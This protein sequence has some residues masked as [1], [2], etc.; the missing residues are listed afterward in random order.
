MELSTYY[1]IFIFTF[2][3]SLFTWELWV[4]YGVVKGDSVKIRYD[5]NSLKNAIIMSFGDALVIVLI[6]YICVLVFK[7]N[8]FKD[9]K[10]FVLFYILCNFQ[11]IIVSILLKKRIIN[12][13]ISIAPLIP[14]KSK[15]SLL[16]L[17]E[18]WLLFPLIIYPLISNSYL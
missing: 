16:Q 5:K 11:N 4:S 15:Y 8:A 2:L 14:I 17:Q 9:T 3:F 1:K 10:T 18:P 7:E 6:V 12:Q 13:D